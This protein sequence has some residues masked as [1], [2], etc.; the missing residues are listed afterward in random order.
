MGS[1]EV[2]GFN[3]VRA[4][5]G[6]VNPG[7]FFHSGSHWVSLGLLGFAQVV[8]ALTL[9]VDWIIRCRSFNLGSP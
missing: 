8:V 9:G 4:G 3:P 7:S 1:S 6:W 5:G 2:V